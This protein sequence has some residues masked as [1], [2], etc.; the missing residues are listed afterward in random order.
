MFHKK[1]ITG[2]FVLALLLTGY[3]DILADDSEAFVLAPGQTIVLGPGEELVIGGSFPLQQGG[4]KINMYRE[5][6]PSEIIIGP[7][8]MIPMLPVSGRIENQVSGSIPGPLNTQSRPDQR[9]LGAAFET[10]TSLQAV[11]PPGSALLSANTITVKG[12]ALAR[13][14]DVSTAMNLEGCEKAAQAVRD[15]EGNIRLTN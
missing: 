12:V 3:G 5:N 7:S 2:L 10:V 11:L 1:W 13:I 9:Q 4:P 8:Q 14:Q 15:Q 6:R